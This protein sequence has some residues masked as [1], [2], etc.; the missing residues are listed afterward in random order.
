MANGLDFGPIKQVL[1]GFGDGVHRANKPGK[2]AVGGS[3]VDFGEPGQRPSS[4]PFP[5]K[6]LAK[7]GSVG[8]G[9]KARTA[10][11]R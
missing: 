8:S 9:Q 11:G 5:Q 1:P 3:M 10:K 4:N 6:Q 2:P 7:L